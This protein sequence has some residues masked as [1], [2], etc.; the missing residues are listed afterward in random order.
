MVVNRLVT[1]K[2]EPSSVINF[3][4]TEKNKLCWI[5]KKKSNVNG[6]RRIFLV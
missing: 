1:Y 6:R 3:M 5:K 2:F 4:V